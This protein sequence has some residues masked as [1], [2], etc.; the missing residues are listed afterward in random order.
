MTPVVIAALVCAALALWLGRRRQK[1]RRHIALLATRLSDR[2]RRMLR[3]AVPLLARLPADLH[4]ALEGKI[5]L[6]RD[7][8]TF[9]GCDGLTVTDEMELTIAAQACLLIVNSPL[10][11]TTLRTVLIYP[12]AFRSMLA[13][14]DGYVVREE[15]VVRDGES[16]PHGPVILSWEAVRD[17]GD[18]VN[19][20]LHEFAHQL[21]ALSGDVDGVP[22]LG[23]GQSFEDWEQV[24]LEAFARHQ[25]RADRPLPTVLDTYGAE[26]H[27]EFLAVA[28]ESFFER[29]R[30][31][32]GV[33]PALY[34]E[35]T[36]LLRLD[37]ATWP[38]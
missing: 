32:R 31:L 10:W 24:V 14:D 34:A 21:D 3:R 38:D 33:E 37:P 5:A 29:P 17:S 7:Q 30:Q 11:Y 9:H 4:P 12:G 20:V 16:W 2:D 19:V 22:L 13:E 8:V 36:K 25:D 27:E 35:L 15:E 26:S 1:R 6:F 23:P 18:G 28:I